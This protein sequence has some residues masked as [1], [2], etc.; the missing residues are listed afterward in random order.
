MIIIGLFGS[1]LSIKDGFS[2]AF[3]SFI[4]QSN[5]A[6]ESVN[7]LTGGIRNAESTSASSISNM[8]RQVASLAL[9]YRNAGLSQSESIRRAM[10]EVERTSNNSSNNTKNRWLDAFKNIKNNG[11]NTFGSLTN[12][13]N[14]FS[15][16]TLGMLSKITAGYLSLRGVIGIT[17]DAMKSGMEYQNAST[18]LQATYGE[19]EGK[20]KFK[21]A[22]QEANK[23]PFTESEVANG[24]ARSH[25]LGLK[26]DEKS[27]KLYED[28]GSFAKIQG[29]GDL[30]SAIDAI[31]DAQA[32]NWMRLQT[33][34][35]VKRASLE[36]FA[37]NNGYGNFAN[38]QGQVTDKEELMKVLEG[39]M[40][41]KGIA[42]MTDKFAKTLGGRLSTLKGNWEKTL[43]EI[44]GIGEDGAVKDGSIFDN[45]AQG[46]EKLITSVNKFSKSESFDKIYD[47]LSKLGDGLIDCLDYVT[48]HPEVVGTL[49]KLGGGLLG[50]KVAS[51][52]IKPLNTV[53]GLLGGTGGLTSVIGGLG[54]KLLPL[55]AGLMALG[56]VISE[57]GV[58]HKGIN[59]ILNDMYGRTEEN[60]EKVDFV[61]LAGYAT[62]DIGL[63]AQQGL[64]SLTGNEAWSA[65]I[66][67]ERGYIDSK[68]VN[69]NNVLNGLYDNGY[70]STPLKKEEK[71]TEWK[72]IPN[73][74]DN[75][76]IS[77][78]V[79]N[80]NNNN[81]ANKMEVNFNIDTVRETADLDNLMNL[82][83]KRLDK[84]DQ[85]RNNLV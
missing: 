64:A 81:A 36:E 3:S 14:S 53:V 70:S 75:K 45:A 85:T 37:K 35:G 49:I 54:L 12:S 83:L 4:S 58:L 6:K 22:T 71:A 44:V 76:E 32:G 24:L 30:N 33:I 52:L 61:N 43:A 79:N 46:L 5:T 56:S 55:T 66:A 9:E 68:F 65:K 42:G 82:A 1:T 48:E 62:Q 63:M 72:T 15:N 21:W 20:E 80:T 78:I 26:D 8:T 74:I 69:S 84:Y 2:K 41:E 28:M 40:G 16:S 39:Y 29:V 11:S 57:N 25:A 7:N 31:A 51:G 47:E 13:I 17:K 38:K 60:Q 67:K 77:S 34:T 73:M 27:F 50:L 59:S 18:F 23:T 10:S 19:V